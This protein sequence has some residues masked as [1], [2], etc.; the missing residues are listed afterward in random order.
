MSCMNGFAPVHCKYV[1][2]KP[3]GRQRKNRKLHALFFWRKRTQFQWLA[4]NK[5]E[6]R[7]SKRKFAD[8]FFYK[9]VLSFSLSQHCQKSTTIKRGGIIRKSLLQSKQLLMYGILMLFG[10]YD[11]DN[12]SSDSSGSLPIIITHLIQAMRNTLPFKVFPLQ[13]FTMKFSIVCLIP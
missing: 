4:R 2:G 13:K 3:S 11:E 8:G 6:K 5:A 10:L 12:L 7:S 9:Y 1:P